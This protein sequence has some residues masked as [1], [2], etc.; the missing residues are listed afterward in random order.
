MAN[1]RVQRRFERL[2]N[3]VEEPA[4]AGAWDSVARIAQEVLYLESENA[5]A[6]HF[7]EAANRALD[8]DKQA[9]ITEEPI[10]PT[11]PT[12]S[13]AEPKSFADGRY[14][15]KRFLRE[16]GKKKVYLAHDELLDRDIAFAP[17]SSRSWP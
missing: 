6:V 12:Q 15:V 2:L 5:D 1:E 7:F 11:T 9:V 10:S 17:T 13:S 3:Q 16:G 4:D 14:Q 8:G